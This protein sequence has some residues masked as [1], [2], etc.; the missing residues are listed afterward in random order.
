MA[1]SLVPCPG[2]P[3]HSSSSSCPSIGHWGFFARLL[4]GKRT[5]VPP[6]SDDCWPLPR[7]EI[8][9]AVTQPYRKSSASAMLEQAPYQSYQRVGFSKRQNWWKQAGSA[10]PGYINSYV[11]FCSSLADGQF[12]RL[13]QKLLSLLPG[14]LPI[15]NHPLSIKILVQGPL[16]LGPNHCRPG[17]EHRRVTQHYALFPFS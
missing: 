2:C 4:A 16:P 1:V 15:Y 7:P 10:N 3:R 12:N 14:L 17:C 13:P 8:I 9:T 11:S 5:G 6:C